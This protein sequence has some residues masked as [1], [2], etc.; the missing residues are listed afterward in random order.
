MK[1]N[2][3]KI[4]V[5]EAVDKL[6]AQGEASKAAVGNE[7]LYR[8]PKGLCC[9]VGFMMDDKTAMEAD[10][11]PDSGVLD[12]VQKSLWGE[13]LTNEQLS[14]V[15]SLQSCHDFVD[16][17]KPFNQEF[18]EKVNNKPTLRWVSEHIRARGKK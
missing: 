14:Q 8:G 13:H 15:C 9:I 17:K 5:I 7:C 10:S 4:M 3:F 18:T 6:L 12:I 16:G 11:Y 2:D 1:D